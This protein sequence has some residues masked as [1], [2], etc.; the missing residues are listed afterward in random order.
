MCESL[1]KE[2]ISEEPNLNLNFFIKCFL[3]IYKH[4]IGINS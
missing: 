2:N 3:N 4:K 1:L